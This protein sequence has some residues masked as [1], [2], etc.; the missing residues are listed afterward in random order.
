MLNILIVDDNREFREN[1]KIN[2]AKYHQIFEATNLSESERVLNKTTIDLAL[3][4]LKLGET[5]EGFE[6]IKIIKEISPSTII[7][8]ITGYGSVENAIKALK[9]GAKDFLLKEKNI[10]SVLEQKILEIEDLVRIQSELVVLKDRDFSEKFIIGV[11]SAMNNLYNQIKQIAQDKDVAVMIVGET[12][13]GKELVAR[14]IHQLSPRVNGPFIPVDCP[15]IPETLFESELF[16]YEKGA[17]SGAVARKLGKIELAHQG[18][19][20]LDEISEL[21]YNLQA[22]FLRVLQEKKFMRLGGEKEIFSDFRLLCATNQDLSQRVKNKQFREDL[23]YR[24]NAITITVPPLR[25]RKE[26]ISHLAKYFL[27]K[28]SKSKGKTLDI[29]NQTLEY[30][31]NYD[32][33]GNVRELER[34]IER[35]V[36][37]SEGAKIDIKNLHFEP[38]KTE[39]FSIPAGL[40]LEEIE[41]R[42]IKYYLKIYKDKRK[43]A[44]ILGIAPS[45]LYEKLKKYK[46]LGE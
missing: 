32:W 40:S 19:L 26:D 30:F 17:F 11:S 41:K 35:M 8:V 22:K 37:L 33:P 43:V 4:D 39:S 44:K 20:F 31:K 23:F 46:I 3:V 16:G 42:A 18:T 45:T 12:G 28:F 38:I 34:T 1:L 10:T 7:F 14:T 36:V 2:F 5:E 21:P 27:S 29:D 9:S 24:I 13:T 25:E 6:V 15:S